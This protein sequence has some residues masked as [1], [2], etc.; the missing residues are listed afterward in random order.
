VRSST[1]SVS[2]SDCWPGA[3]VSTEGI[4]IDRS[5]AIRCQ[6]VYSMKSYILYIILEIR[7]FLR[8]SLVRVGPFEIARIGE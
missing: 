7:L 2:S 5:A 1:S 8:E 6:E 4:E 3:C